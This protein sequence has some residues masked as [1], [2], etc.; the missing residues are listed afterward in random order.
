M[1]ENKHI[2][3]TG[4]SRGLGRS[5]AEACHRRGARLSLCARSSDTLLEITSQTNSLGAAL[6]VSDDT[7]V[8]RWIAA[9]VSQYGP[10]YAVVNNAALLGP[11]GPL[12]DYSSETF[13]RVLDVNLRGAFVVTQT[14]LPHMV[15]PGGILCQITSFLGQTALPNYGAYCVSK[16][17]LE[18]FTYL[19]AAE[20]GDEGLISC[21]VDPGMV[22]SQMLQAALGQEDVSE[23]TPAAE[24][25]EALAQ[26]LEGLSASDNGRRLELYPQDGS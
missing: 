8:S 3:I 18:G 7:A 20:H 11:M 22:Q 25:G 17:G 1:L 26:L 14:A 15:R 21:T 16:F 4:A 13:G 23:F 12:K 19:L 6:D 5:L 2:L 9:A 10:I 24:A